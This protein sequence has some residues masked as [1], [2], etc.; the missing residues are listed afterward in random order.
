M[1][2]PRI[3]GLIPRALDAG[4]MMGTNRIMAGTASMK[5]PTNIKNATTTRRNTSQPP[6]MLAKNLCTITFS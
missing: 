6:A 4:R 1:I 2:R 5:V 3:M